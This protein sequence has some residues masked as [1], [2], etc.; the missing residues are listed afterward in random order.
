MRWIFLTVAPAFFVGLIASMVAALLA[1]IM[2][3]WWQYV[4]ASLA[5]P[6]IAALPVWLICG[7]VAVRLKPGAGND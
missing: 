1:P 4:W 2:P 5:F 6:T 7:A 3:T